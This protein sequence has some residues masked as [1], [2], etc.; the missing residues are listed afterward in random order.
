[1]LLQRLKQRGRQLVKL[2]LRVSSFSKLCKYS[3]VCFTVITFSMCIGTKLEASSTL[4]L[5]RKLFYVRH[6]LPAKNLVQRDRQL[7]NLFRH[8]HFSS[9]FC[10][11]FPTQLIPQSP[12]TRSPTPWFGLNFVLNCTD[13]CF[14]GSE[15]FATNLPTIG[16]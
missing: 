5:P 9:S 12:N 4:L 6:Q 11:R 14:Q 10:T 16:N 13:G 3:I 7:Q 15:T 2:R 1:M 8:F